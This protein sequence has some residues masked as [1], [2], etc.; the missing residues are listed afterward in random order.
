MLAAALAA[1]APFVHGGTHF[2]VDSE[3]GS[4]G[5]EGTSWEAAKATITAAIELTA[6]NAGDVVHVAEGT[7]VENLV[8]RE[9][10]EFLGGYPPEGAGERDPEVYET[11]VDGN[12]AQSCVVGAHAA[13][14]DG[15]TLTNGRADGGGGI[16]MSACSMTVKDCRIMGN[17]AVKGNPFGG[18]GIYLLNSTSYFINC[19]V[20]GNVMEMPPGAAGSEVTGGGFHMWTSAPTFIDCTFADNHVVLLD[21]T[22]NKVT[23]GGG[24][25]FVVSYP[26]FI[27]CLF[28]HNSASHGGGMGWWHESEPRIESCVFYQNECEEAGAGLIAIWL[29]SGV[30]E[31]YYKIKD[32]VFQE[33]VAFNGGGA[34]VFRNAKVEFENCLFFENAALQLGGAFM[35]AGNCN[36]RLTNCTVAD[37]ELRHVIETFGSGIYISDD[38]GM[39]LKDSIVAFNRLGDGIHY[40]GALPDQAIK[41]YHTDIYGHSTGGD[42]GGTIPDIFGIDGNIS[43][44]PLFVTGELDD[45][46]LSEPSTGAP[47]QISLGRSP[48]INAGSRESAGTPFHSRFTR[49]DIVPDFGTLDMGYHRI[50]PRPYFTE[51]E[52]DYDSAGVPLSTDIR[53]ELRDL[54]E[55]I[56]LETITMKVNDQEVIPEVVEDYKAA[57]LHYVPEQ[58]FSTCEQVKIS[59]SV[60]DEGSPSGSLVDEFY[61]FYTEGCSP[62]PTPYWSPT[63]SPFPTEN[64]RDPE[65]SLHLNRQ[66]Y[67]AN[68]DFLLDAV[69]TN[70]GPETRADLYV[71]LD[72]YGVLYFY[73][74]WTQEIRYDF[75]TVPAW[76]IETVPI[77]EFVLPEPLG[78]GGPFYFYAVLTRPGTTDLFGEAASVHFAF[79]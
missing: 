78:A 14:F 19:L 4:D 35:A 49:T 30:Q 5:N 61:Y 39:E 40:K 3:N 50:G 7:Y 75:R 43:A 8:L 62:T 10:T 25:W 74:L 41:I 53:L 59:V 67:R 51:M 24:G 68:D 36:V 31:H 12:Q 32:C 45:Y 18:G 76:S 23:L 11:T 2:Y 77:L 15:F 69:I 58:Y 63:P 17:K 70:M 33:N 71:A 60:Q 66:V 57:G 13:Y 6:A 26:T 44:D 52:P 72:V 16:R 9:G 46:Y 38:S 22:E 56:N 54:E 1:A 64:P 65:I 47:A 55:G 79:E 42:I 20:E 37:N 48:C 34:A 29:D 73:P 28:T 21:P 27:N